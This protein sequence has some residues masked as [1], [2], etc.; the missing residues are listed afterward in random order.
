VADDGAD[1]R[2]YYALIWKDNQ[3]I[4]AE[5]REW[6]RGRSDRIRQLEAELTELRKGEQQT[7]AALEAA[8]ALS[9]IGQPPRVVRDA[10]PV[11]QLQQARLNVLSSTHPTRQELEDREV[12]YVSEGAA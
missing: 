4:A 8:K 5:L 6:A 3:A 10:A 9:H 2:A 1:A 7:E 12:A 11:E